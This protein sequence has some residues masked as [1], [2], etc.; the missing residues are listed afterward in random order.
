[1]VEFWLTI[2]P[3]VWNSQLEG[4]RALQPVCACLRRSEAWYSPLR[5]YDRP[6][7]RSLSA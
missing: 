7:A 2:S 6:A 4:C 3:I 5:R 1:M